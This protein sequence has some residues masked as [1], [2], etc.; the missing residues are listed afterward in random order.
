MD[1]KEAYNIWADQ[2][3]TNE[4]KTRDL[5]AISLEKLWL[6]FNLRIVWRL[7]AEQGKIQ[8]GL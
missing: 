6:T 3:D 8:N 1:V 5:V 2:Y 7:V 4:N